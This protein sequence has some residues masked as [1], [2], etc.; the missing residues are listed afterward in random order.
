MSEPAARPRVSVIIPAYNRADM[1]RLMLDQLLRQTLP[2]EQFEVVIADDGSSDG[3]EQVVRPYADRLRLTYFFQEDQGNRVCKARNEA[4]RIATAPLLVLLD[5]GSIPGPGLLARYVAAYEERPDRAVVGYAWGYNPERE[6]FP[7][8]AEALAELPPEQVVEK[9]RADPGFND[10]RDRQYVLDDFDLE[11]APLPWRLLYTLNCAVPAAAFAAAGGFNEDFVRWG[12]EDQNF[13]MRLA[14]V[15]VPLHLDREAWIVEWP[16]ERD[17]ETQWPQY[18]ENSDLFLREFPEPSVEMGNTLAHTGHYWEWRE[19]WLEFEAWTEQARKIDVRD[20]LAEAARR[21]DGAGR[22][23]VFGCGGELPAGFAPAAVLEFDRDLLERAVRGAGPDAPDAHHLIGITALLPDQSADLVLITS[24]LSGLWP[25]WGERILSEAHR[26][27]GAV[28]LLD[29][30][31]GDA[32]GTGT[33]ADL[34]DAVN[35]VDA[36]EAGL[37]GT[38]AAGANVTEAGLTEM[39]AA[40]AAPADAREG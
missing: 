12:A 9:F 32:A 17:G 38:A 27:G 5:A 18:L 29:P 33:A 11:R 8:L 30:A 19:L 13:G 6:G 26:I 24:R 37:T 28:A 20:E 40:D 16:H 25:S 31:L 14:K 1:V 22:V 34:A 4:A 3:L 2:L 10:I 39:A 15:G 23:V 7:G 21:Y 36:V 35:A